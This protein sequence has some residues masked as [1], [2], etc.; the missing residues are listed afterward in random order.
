MSNLYVYKHVNTV[1]TQQ[2]SIAFHYTIPLLLRACPMVYPCI[3]YCPYQTGELGVRLAA[4]LIFRVI[5][6][7]LEVVA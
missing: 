3:D 2:R 4:V 1:N 6:H 7:D 5:V